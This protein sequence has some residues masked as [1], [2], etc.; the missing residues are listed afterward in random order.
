MI[1]VI[2]TSFHPI[3]H[4][5]ANLHKNCKMPKGKMHSN[6]G[7]TRTPYPPSLFLGPVKIPR[8]LLKILGFPFTPNCLNIIEPRF[9]PLTARGRLWRPAEPTIAD[10]KLQIANRKS[11]ISLPSTIRLPGLL[12]PFH[13]CYTFPTPQRKGCGTTTLFAWRSMP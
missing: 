10:R 8:I 2:H 12:S 11:H 7:S 6:R 9:E 3:S 13:I 5:L 4:T 1:P